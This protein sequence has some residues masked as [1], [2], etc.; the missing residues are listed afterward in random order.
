MTTNVLCRSACILRHRRM[1]ELVSSESYQIQR[2]MKVFLYPYSSYYSDL[3]VVVET[4]VVVTLVITVIIG[5]VTEV[6]VV[7]LIV[8][9]VVVVMVVVVVVVVVVVTVNSRNSSSSHINYNCCNRSISGSICSS[10]LS[11]C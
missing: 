7:V 4:V 11:S 9:V 3:V 2:I 8:I 5:V 10:S 6:S 1:Q